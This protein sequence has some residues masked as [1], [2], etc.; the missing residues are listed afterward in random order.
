MDYKNNLDIIE[1]EENEISI[2]S[3]LSD[4]ISKFF[5]SIFKADEDEDEYEDENE[6]SQEVKKD[7]HVNIYELPK[8]ISKNDLDN[9][10]KYYI[11][12]DDMPKTYEK[13]CEDIINEKIVVIKYC[14]EDKN[15]YNEISQLFY[16]YQKGKN[17]N[18]EKLK[19]FLYIYIPENVDISGNNIKKQNFGKVYKLD[20]KVSDITVDRD[21]D[22][23]IK[24][25]DYI[26]GGYPVIIRYEDIS[27]IKNLSVEQKTKFSRNVHKHHDFI[28]GV[29]YFAEYSMEKV[30]DTVFIVV[31]KQMS[32]KIQKPVNIKENTN[33]LRKDQKNLT[34]YYEN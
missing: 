16:G 27:E 31:P 30:D 3:K 11:L 29:V 25:V 20:I 21:K 6:T 17:G 32:I 18:I 14:F 13:V 4:G 1:D 34:I 33:F 22:D 7:S 9:E 10:I 5:S 8:K 19:D 28:T 23:V 2:F 12:Q 15:K 26:R 24:M